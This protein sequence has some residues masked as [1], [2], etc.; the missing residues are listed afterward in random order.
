MS[1][2]H[3]LHLIQ[4]NGIVAMYADE[5]KKWVVDMYVLPFFT[6]LRPRKT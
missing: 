1:I 6:S 3:V 2:L 4:S 5:N